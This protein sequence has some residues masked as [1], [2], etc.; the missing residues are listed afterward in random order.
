MIRNSCESVLINGNQVNNLRI[1]VTQDG[2]DGA[3][4]SVINCPSGNGTI[5]VMY[6]EDGAV[7]AF[8]SSI[9]YAY[10]TDTVIMAGKGNHRFRAVTLNAYDVKSI[11]IDC[12]GGIEGCNGMVIHL[13]SVCVTVYT[14][15]Y[16]SKLTIVY[17]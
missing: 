9:I 4:K 2:N 1:I 10:E 8:E 17:I 5:C 13:N 3:G 7:G 11:Y 14:F 16:I 12:K 15:N 6:S